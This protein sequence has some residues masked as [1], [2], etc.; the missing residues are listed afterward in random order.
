MIPLQGRSYIIDHDEELTFYRVTATDWVEGLPTHNKELRFSMFCNVQPMNARDLLLV[1][2]GDRHR[3]QY[4]VW[5]ENRHQNPRLETNDRVVRLG[6]NFQV[7]SVEPWGTYVRAR[8]ML[9]D[10]GPASKGKT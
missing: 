1:P 3:E 9:D 2:E 7:Q 10:V 4:W 8:L 6:K 5:T